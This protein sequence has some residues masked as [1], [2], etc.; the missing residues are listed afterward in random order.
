MTCGL[1]ILTLVPLARV[2]FCLV[3]FVKERDSMYVAFTAYVLIAL[4][5]GVMLG[6]I[7]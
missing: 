4:L 7:G 5:A 3:L 1:F 2:A 6:K